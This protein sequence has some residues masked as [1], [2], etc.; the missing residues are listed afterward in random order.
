MTR[1]LGY[2]DRIL[3]GNPIDLR[4]ADVPPGGT[5][6][7]ICRV[8]ERTRLSEILVRDFTLTALY[9]GP[10]FVKT[11]ARPTPDGSSAYRVEPADD[12]CA[13][14]AYD[15]YQVEPAGVDV[16]AAVDV[17][18]ILQNNTDLPLHARD[19]HFEEDR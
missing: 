10:N 18:I 13:C 16:P 14:R 5:Y 3:V 4:D 19:A 9:I 6:Q 2:T 15:A 17:R 7:A 8:R 1:R 11:A 12:A